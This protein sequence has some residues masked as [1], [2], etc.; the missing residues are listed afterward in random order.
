MANESAKPA[1]PEPVPAPVPAAA[2]AAAKPSAPLT[3][4]E[5]MRLKRLGKP[6]N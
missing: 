2:A 4:A 5:K 1:T 3:F 6:G